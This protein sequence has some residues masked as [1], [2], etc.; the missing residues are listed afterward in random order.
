MPMENKQYVL[1]QYLVEIKGKNVFINTE[2]LKE[3]LEGES[4][5]RLRD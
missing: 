3:D 1:S 2:Q 4:S 5:N